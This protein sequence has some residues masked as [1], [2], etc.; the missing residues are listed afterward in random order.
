MVMRSVGVVF[1][2]TIVF[3]LVCVGVTCVC[4][5]VCVCARVA[6]RAVCDVCDVCVN[7][8]KV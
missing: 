8:S 7:R 3:G 4:V 6:V 5:C 1:F 2:N